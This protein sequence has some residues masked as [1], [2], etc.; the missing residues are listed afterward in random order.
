MRFHQKIAFG[1]AASRNPSSFV[2]T[3]ATLGLLCS[4]SIAACWEPSDDE[5][6]EEYETE[7]YSCVVIANGTELKI[8]TGGTLV[9]TGGG[10]ENIS[11]I[12][13]TIKLDSDADGATLRITTNDHTLTGGGSIVGVGD[14]AE[15]QV[16]D[17]TTLTSQI[18]IAGCLSID[19]VS[20][21]GRFHNDGM[22]HANAPCVLD[23]ATATITDTPGDRWKVS[24][25]GSAYLRFSSTATKLVGNF[26]VGASATDCG[27][28]DIQ[29]DVTTRGRLDQ[30]AGTTI[31][32][33]TGNTLQV[34]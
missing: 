16:S 9:L 34:S 26:L 4:A 19:E 27:T 32:V 17:G 7:T 5:T 3:L 22:V 28:L 11:T 2:V 24:T 30:K 6:I 8:E 15:I 33:A 20:G 29:A 12:D 23:L 1:H 10:G 25:S 31:R 14:Y 13:G 18:I 21:A